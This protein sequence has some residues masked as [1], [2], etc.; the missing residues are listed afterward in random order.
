MGLC[1]RFIAVRL[2]RDYAHKDLAKTPPSTAVKLVLFLSRTLT[3]A[4]KGKFITKIF[5]SYMI[6]AVSKLEAWTE[7]TKNPVVFY[8]DYIASIYPT[9]PLRTASP[10]RGSLRLIRGAQYLQQFNVNVFHRAGLTKRVADALSRLAN[11]RSLSHPI[12]TR[13]IHKR[14]ILELAECY[15]VLYYLKRTLCFA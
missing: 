2:K 10:G 13:A 11:L 7:A 1:C 8:T 6:Y 12:L 15:Q 5:F 4:E 14:C 9:T 3:P